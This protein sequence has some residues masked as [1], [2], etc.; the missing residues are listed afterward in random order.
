LSKEDRPAGNDR[1]V[2]KGAFMRKSESD[3]MKGQSRFAMDQGTGVQA[4]VEPKRPSILVVTRKG[5]MDE[6]VMDYALNVAE[7]LGYRLLAAY[8]NTLPKYRDGG[9]RNRRFAAAVKESA[10]LFQARADKRRIGFE[11]MEEMGKVGEAV[12]RLCHAAK[13]VEFVVIDHGI[14]MED[15]ASKSPVPVFSVIYAKPKELRRD[16]SLNMEHHNPGDYA[17]SVKSRKRHVSRTLIFGAL[18][19]GLY[20]A[21]FTNSASI[22][23]YFTKGG[24]YALLP[25]ATVFVFS[26]VHGSFTS[27]FW[28]ALGIEGSKTASQKAPQKSGE[29]VATDRTRKDARPRAQVNA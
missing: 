24:V 2:V 18:A 22:M 26:Y 14:R 15:A 4:A 7:R 19:A 21:V 13:R 8:V 16:R 9:E 25:V 29:A 17:M 6:P 3:E 11:H 23:T 12:S 1:R 20:A 28:S 10:A 5:H 27:N